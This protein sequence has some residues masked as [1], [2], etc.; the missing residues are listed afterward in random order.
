MNR[1]ERIFDPATKRRTK[2]RFLAETAI[3]VPQTRGAGLR[4]QPI[5]PAIGARPVVPKP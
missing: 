4:F 2:G 5:S 1:A 3:G